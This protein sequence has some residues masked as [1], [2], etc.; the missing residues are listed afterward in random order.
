METAAIG[1]FVILFALLLVAVSVGS[2]FWDARRKK[3]MASI[4]QTA[5]GEPTVKI[6]SLLKELESDR[7]G[8]LASLLTRLQF[9]KHAHQQIQQAGLAWSP[10]RLIIA[11]GMLAIPGLG[12]GA[13][14]P[15]LLVSGPLSRNGRKAPK[16]LDKME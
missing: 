12:L 8:G 4:L 15:F 1:A 9:S 5:S 13:F 6:A 3:T 16:R 2:K 11:M 14:L 7:K 10:S